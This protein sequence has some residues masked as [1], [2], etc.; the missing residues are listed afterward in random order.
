MNAQELWEE[1]CEKKGVDKETDYE[2]WAFCGGGPSGDQLAQ[3]VLNG[4]KFGTASPLDA[5][6]ENEEEEPI[7][8]VGDYSVI[9]LDS[10]EAV[11]VL[12]D[13]EVSLV[14]FSKVTYFHGYS[15]GEEERTDVT[16]RRIHEDAFAPDLESLGKPLNGD[17][18]VVCEKFCVEYIS[19]TPTVKE[20]LTKQSL[21]KNVCGPTG[22]FDFEKYPSMGEVGQEVFY[23][24]PCMTYAKQIAE[25]RKELLEAGSDFDGCLSLKRCENIEDWVEHC[26]E[27]ADPSLER[28]K[29]RPPVSVIMCVRKADNKIVGMMQVIHEY[30]KYPFFRDCAGQI[31][32]SVCPSERR[33]GYAKKLLRKAIDF[34]RAYGYT[35]VWLSCVKENEASRRT[36]LSNGGEYR[37][38][39]YVEKDKIFLER[40]EIKY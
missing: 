35:S 31:G 23:V 36:I 12:R 17:T 26:R 2:S 32:Y 21:S 1:F 3:L 27:F 29:D 25:Y 8:Q 38:T 9:L 40:Y 39:V 37:D 13:Y 5:Y 30:E 16:W 10:G 20:L 34:C 22:D 28:P 11:C 19:D 14:P 7:P 6:Y 15:E 4:I 24:E 33:K 18:M